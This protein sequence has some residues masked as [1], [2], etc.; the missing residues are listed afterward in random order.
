MLKGLKVHCTELNTLNV[1]VSKES[2]ASSIYTVGPNTKYSN[3]KD[4]RITTKF[5]LDL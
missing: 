4:L 1:H 5:D 3:Y 2:K